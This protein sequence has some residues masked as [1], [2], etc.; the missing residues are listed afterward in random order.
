MALAANK[1]YQRKDGKLE[2]MLVMNNVHIY[3]GALLVVNATGYVEPLTEAADKYF[4]GI[5]YEECDTTLAGYT[6]T[7]GLKS[8]RVV[9]DGIFLL[10]A[11]SIALTDN[12]APM[13]GKDDATVDESSTLSTGVKV[14]ILV[15]Y[16]SNTSG[17][18]D[19]GQGIGSP[20][21]AT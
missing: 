11:A 10:A 6:V 14:G 19:I 16:V 8:V 18:V 15:E 17:W 20:V 3:K 4:V 5:A 12:G 1:D 21:S 2:S 13:Y 9:R 7:P